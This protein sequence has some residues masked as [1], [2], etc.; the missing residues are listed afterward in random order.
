M[1]W[2]SYLKLFFV[3]III[4]WTT[5]SFRIKSSNPTDYFDINKEVIQLRRDSDSSG[6]LFSNLQLLRSLSRDDIP[7]YLQFKYPARRLSH[8]DYYTTLDTNNT[9]TLPL[10]NIMKSGYTGVV[11]IG[12]PKQELYWIFDTGSSIMF[13]N[14]F[15]WEIDHWEDNPQYDPEEST[16]ADVPEITKP[17]QINYGGG[18]LKGN[19]IKDTVWLHDMEIPSQDIAE[20]TDEDEGSTPN[21]S[22]LIGLGYPQLAPHGELLLFDNI[23]QRKL[24]EKNIFT[25]Y[26]YADGIHSDLVFGRIDSKYYTGDIN[27]VDVQ[28][29]YHWNIKIDDIKIG[30]K[31]M[32]FCPK[33][34]QGL[35]DS[36][37]NLNTF[38]YQEYLS[39]GKEINYSSDNK[40]KEL[41]KYPSLT[42]VIGGVDY[43]F[44]PEEYFAS[45][46]ENPEN[47]ELGFFPMDVFQDQD[48]PA[49]VIGVQFMM[50]YFTIYDRDFNQVGFALASNLEVNNKESNEVDTIDEMDP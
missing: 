19:M 12:N 14:S 40:W 28:K 26:Y 37:T 1:V 23:M 13:V 17:I 33:G 25:T 22:W 8:T 9:V 35:V 16:S 41:S 38:E 15:Y 43:T 21:F 44:T 24:L 30:G 3:L 18:F 49:M 29:Q 39:I 7:S 46:P 45:D 31:P 20:V 10:R 42:Y 11:D 5:N 32:N 4:A 48:H 2:L 34:W 50:K 6:K 47:W 27:Y 36:G